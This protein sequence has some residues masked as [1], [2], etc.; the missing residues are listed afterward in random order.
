VSLPLEGLR[1]LVTIPPHTWFGGVDFNFA[2]EMA[3]ELRSRGATVFE[4]EVAG[5]VVHNQNLIR[6]AIQ[7]T[8]SFRPDVALPLPNAGYGILCR[9]LDQQNLFKDIL[10]VPTV[11]LWDHGLL[12]F[13]KICLAPL[14]KSHLDATEGAL[15][16][17]KDML[18]HPLYHH[19][20]PDHGHMAALERLGA[21]DANQVHF[22]LQPA[23]P[24][25]VQHGYRMAPSN[26][27]RTRVAFAGNVYLQAARD[28]P[29][30][31]ENT[32][33]AIEERVMSRK[34]AQLNEPLWDLLTAEIDSLDPSRRDLLRLGPD[35]TFFWSFMHDE[36]EV[37]GNTSVRLAVLSKLKHEYD[38]Y[39]NFIEPDAV[40]TLRS[41]YN[42]TFRKSLDYF[43]ELPLLFMN[44]DI[45]VDVINL[46][47]NTGVSPKV[48]GCLACGGLVLFD[49]KADFHD[50]LGEIGDQ[51]M[52]RDVDHLNA[53]VDHYLT[54]PRRRRDVSR[55]LQYRISTEFS[56]G[57]LCNR[58]LVEE[59]LWR[60]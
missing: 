25:F 8:I 5:F 20:S 14:P 49:Y 45:I 54:N 52:Y 21:V 19:Y 38:F 50:C 4:L 42:V 26:A 41:R 10:Q 16:R 9:T 11:M 18:S 56:F 58:L 46:G 55:Y 24:N 15:Q 33:N 23:Y 22:F 37:V 59:P 6:K 51:I 27:F 30:R 35:S 34:T 48:M 12:Q 17:L 53:L 31:N 47:Y 13:P 2:V 60:N 39:G 43:T 36:I 40:S 7:E 57:N 32:L 1:V 28:L 3:E 44:S 29:F